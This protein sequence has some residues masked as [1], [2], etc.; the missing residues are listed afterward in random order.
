VIESRSRFFRRYDL[1][2]AARV[3]AGYA[4][5]IVAPKGEISIA[6]ALRVAARKKL[7]VEKQANNDTVDLVRID[8]TTDGL[9]VLLFHRTSPTA[10]DPA[11]RKQKGD[12]ITLRMTRKGAGEDQA[13]SAHLVISTKISPMGGYPCALEEINGL[14][15]STVSSIIKKALD[16]YNYPYRDKKGIEKETYSTFKAL[17]I[18]G[19]SLTDALHNNSSINYLTLTRTK[20]PDAPDSD[21]IAEPQSERIRYKIVGD[22]KSPE[23]MKKLRLFETKIRSDDWDDIF[24]DISLEDERHRT[25]KL[26]REREA[27]E[28]MFVRSE[29]VSVERDLDPCTVDI[30]PELVSAAKKLIVRK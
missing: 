18:K 15:L 3:K 29:Q 12:D 16:G 23:W 28:V 30:V 1:R 7:C 21:G 13:V 10:A 6:D 19:E 17:G 11:Y 24:L 14:S 20:V 22:P 4:L 9:L 26:D 25:V 27:A 5:P 8:D 2:F